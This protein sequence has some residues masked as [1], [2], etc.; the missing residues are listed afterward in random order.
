MSPYRPILSKSKNMVEH[1]CLRVLECPEKNG[2]LVGRPFWKNGLI[3]TIKIGMPMQM[4]ATRSA[5][6]KPESNSTLLSKA[7]RLWLHGECN[8]PSLC[9]T[10][11]SF[12]QCCAPRSSQVPKGCPCGLELFL[13]VVASQSASQLLCNIMQP[14]HSCPG[15]DRWA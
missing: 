10:K 8:W 11:Q 13:E 12:K 3:E 7:G 1:W 9:L 15:D 6:P 4:V 14:V 2:V 5:I